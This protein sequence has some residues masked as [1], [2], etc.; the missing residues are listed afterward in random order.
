MPK[1]FTILTT[2]HC[3]FYPFCSVLLIQTPAILL[4]I[5]I[6]ISKSKTMTKNR[7]FFQKRKFSSSWLKAAVTLKGK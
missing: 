5:I 1:Q 2:L 7:K 4:I 6:F 3:L